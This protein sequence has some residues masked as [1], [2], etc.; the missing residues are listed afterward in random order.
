MFRSRATT[1][2]P[3]RRPGQ[4]EQ[5]LR[6]WLMAHDHQQRDPVEICPGVKHKDRD[7]AG[8]GTG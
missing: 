8:S 5:L 7:V 2:T 4:F 1:L 3:S 6:D